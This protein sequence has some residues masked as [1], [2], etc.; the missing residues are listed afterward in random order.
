MVKGK[1]K[2]CENDALH[3]LGVCTYLLERI[4]TFHNQE[5]AVSSESSAVDDSKT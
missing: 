3:G 2:N 4:K 5:E 1:K